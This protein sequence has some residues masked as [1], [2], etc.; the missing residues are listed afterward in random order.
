MITDR[1]RAAFLG[2]F[3]VNRKD[4]HKSISSLMLACIF[5]TFLWENTPNILTGIT[6][7]ERNMEGRWAG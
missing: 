1:F 3:Y 4:T 6:T 7:G 5:K 2:L